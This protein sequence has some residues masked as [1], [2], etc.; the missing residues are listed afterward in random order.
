M[1]DFRIL[2]RTFLQSAVAGGAWHLL[3][4]SLSAFQPDELKKKLDDLRANLL[5]LVNEER[6]VHK[7]PLLKHDDFA[8]KI[9]QAHAEDMAVHEYVSHWGRD[10]LK[11]YQRY[12]FAGSHHAVQ[13]NVSAADNTWSLKFEDL[14]QDTSYLHVRMYNEKPPSDGHRKAILA[15]QHTHVGFGIAVNNLRLR[16]VELFVSKY[17]EF[18]PMLQAA[19]PLQQIHLAGKVIRNGVFLN[20]VEVHYEPLP[21]PPGLAWLNEPRGY[22]LPDESDVLVPKLPRPLFYANRKPGTIEIEITGDFR[23][24]VHLYKSTPG[25]YSIVCWVQR[26]RSEKP[27]PVTNLCVRAE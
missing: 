21:N 25:I 1:V 8:T 13:E 4:P 17:I 11:P 9:A 7:V 3:N 24:P 26:N 14:K 5:Q 15:P 6:D 10:G 20:S 16:M 23:V 19:K 12:S 2:R 18:K 27:F 22:A